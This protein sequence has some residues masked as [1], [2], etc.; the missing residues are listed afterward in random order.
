MT[1]EPNHQH[2]AVKKLLS[3]AA[4]SGI[5]FMLAA[6]AISEPTRD[7]LWWK[8][9]GSPK[10]TCQVAGWLT[11]VSAHSPDASGW[12][13]SDQGNTYF[14]AH[15][16][17]GQLATA[18]VVVPNQDKPW[19]SWQLAGDSDVALACFTPGYAKS[20]DR[21]ENQRRLKRITLSLDG[22]EQTIRFPDLDS[23]QYQ[24]LLGDRVRCPSCK[25]I[26]LTIESTYPAG[27]NREVAIS[28]ARFYADSR[29]PPLRWLFPEQ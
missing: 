27:K 18:W 10:L 4:I 5:G 14:P 12:L 8:I 22:R 9:S 28:E 2:G 16:V 17:D 11:E 26:V 21:F 13:G 19:I 1:E 23:S 15:S 3:A 20:R 29:L 6:P 25:L 7:W 24:S